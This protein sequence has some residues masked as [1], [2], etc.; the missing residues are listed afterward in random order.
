MENKE[1][2]NG[3]LIIY[4][5]YM[6]LVYYS[7]DL[8]RKFPK[9][10]QFALVK[11][12]KSTLYS[13]LRCIIYAIKLYNKQDKLRYLRELDVNLNLLKVHIRISYKYKY[14]TMNNYQTWSNQL[15]DISN[16]LGGW[17]NSCLKR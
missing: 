3:T 1:K 11:E 6:D 9:C 15:T 7:N 10:E 13:G 2:K 14:I 17:I 4:P 16:L 12:I 5:K 8:V